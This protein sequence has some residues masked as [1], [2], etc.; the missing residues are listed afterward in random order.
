M[1]VLTHRMG[2]LCMLAQSFGQAAPHH[3]G[4]GE[5]REHHGAGRQQ[6]EQSG[7]GSAAIRAAAF[8]AASAIPAP[9]AIGRG[10]QAVLE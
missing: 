1:A 8:A 4:A 6:N 7:K 10:E 3:E 9:S 5:R 2:G